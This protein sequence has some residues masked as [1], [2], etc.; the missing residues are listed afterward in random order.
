MSD[1]DASSV[2]MCVVKDQLC[3][4]GLTSMPC[5]PTTAPKIFHKFIDQEPRYLN[6]FRQILPVIHH[7]THEQRQIFK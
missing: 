5:S 4:Y 6:N 7:G 1:T 3:D 2:V